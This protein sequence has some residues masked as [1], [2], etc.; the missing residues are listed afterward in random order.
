MNVGGNGTTTGATF[1][2]G[3]SNVNTASQMVT[4]IG[5]E[6]ATDF[7]T[8]SNSSGASAT[9]TLSGENAGAADNVSLATYGTAGSAGAPAPADLTLSGST[10]T[11]GT[12][13]PGDTAT[14]FNYWNGTGY[15]TG[16]Q[17]ATDLHDALLANSIVTTTD[18]IATTN[19][20]PI[21]FSTTDAGAGPFPI[22]A[23]NFSAFPGQ[24]SISEAAVTAAVQPNAYPAKYGASLTSASCTNDFV[25]YP[26]GEAGG[27]AAPT[28][29]AY[30]NLYSS[31]TGTVPSV[32]WAYNTGAGYSV[33]TSPILS[34]DGSKVAFIQS[35]GTNADLVVVKLAP[36]GTLASPVAPASSGNI[37]TCTPAPCMTVTALGHNDTYSSPFYDYSGSPGDILWVGDNSGN[38]EAFSGVF[39]GAVAPSGT[40]ALGS[41]AVSSPVLDTVS[42]YIFVGDMGGTLYSVGSGTT[43]GA[44]AGVVHGNTG[45]IADAFADAPLVDSNTGRV[46]A[47]ANQSK[48]AVYTG[49]NVVFGLTTAFTNATGIGTSPITETVDNGATGHYLYAGGFDNVYFQSGTGTGNIYA[50]GDTGLTTGASLY[51]IGLSAGNL[52]GGSAVTQAATGLSDG[53]AWPSPLTEFCNGACT[54]TTGGTCGT[55]V[56][57]TNSGTDYVFFSVNQGAKE[58]CT[59]TAGN[60]CIMSYNVSN[61]GTVSTPIA[62]VFSGAQNYPNVGT[63]GCWA[64][65]GIVIDNDASTTGASEIYFTS[66]N[67]AEAVNPGSACSAGSPATINAIQAEQNAP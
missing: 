60:G 37:T 50:V 24:G 17:L 38:L 31:C 40:V 53:Y 9:V 65:G 64:T 7:V 13:G 48:T 28:I 4:A 52:I 30:N 19:A 23:Q 55:G 27:T 41:N 10:L 36:G 42:G 49:D 22:S 54:V 43:V 51:R 57:C 11:G 61:P 14:T 46:F 8:A 16:S 29:I 15:D 47:F 45:V 12:N 56:T 2:I 18:K 39:Y 6:T 58:G 67:G 44:P 3:S 66:L 33:T 32:L 25:V 20:N 1:A 5:N 26:T 63:I 35:N 34:L 62:A 59:T 21:T